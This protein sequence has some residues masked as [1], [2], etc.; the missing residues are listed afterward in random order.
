MIST[1]YLR[2][3]SEPAPMV[4]IVEDDPDVRNMVAAA[5]DQV[6][7]NRAEATSA[8]DALTF[9]YDHA[10][11]V[12]I[13][14][15]DVELPGRV[16]GIDLARVASLRWPWIKVLIATGG[17]RIRDVPENL[18][19]LPKPCRTNDV[20]AQLQWERARGRA[21]HSQTANTAAHRTGERGGQTHE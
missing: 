9:L 2:A 7:A 6:D 16:D 20:R 21:T 19:F 3:P 1:D 12:G 11:D 8:E 5:V 18:V 13:I 10:P 14:F 15:T 4:L 17:E